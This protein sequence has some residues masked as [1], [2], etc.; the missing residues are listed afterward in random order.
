MP[1]IRR[2]ELDLNALAATVSNPNPLSLLPMPEARTPAQSIRTPNYYRQGYLDAFRHGACPLIVENERPVLLMPGEDAQRQVEVYRWQLAACLGGHRPAPGDGPLPG[3]DLPGFSVP[4]GF[5][6]WVVPWGVLPFP[7]PLGGILMAP[8]EQ[9][10]QFYR[11]LCAEREAATEFEAL[12]NLFVAARQAVDTLIQAIRDDGRHEPVEGPIWTKT[13]D[14]RW[15]H[16]ALW[17]ALRTTLIS[18]PGPLSNAYAA[19]FDAYRRALPV[20]Q[21]APSL[22]VFWRWLMEGCPTGQIWTGCNGMYDASDGPLA[23]GALPP[24]YV[25]VWSPD[26]CFMPGSL[27]AACSAAY[28]AQSSRLTLP[29]APDAVTLRSLEQQRRWL[30]DAEAAARAIA[31]DAQK[32]RP[33]SGKGGR[34]EDVHLNEL[35]RFAKRLGFTPAELASLIIERQPDFRD[36]EGFSKATIKERIRK[37]WTATGKNPPAKS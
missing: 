2:L 4:A 34:P 20:K 1:S 25:V 5:H 7:L 6:A 35:I 26:W 27:A 18:P 28:Q 12:P 13:T 3:L 21:P 9:M 11:V 37:R 15:K 10:V 32:L 33:T 22:D 14:A 19:Y 23:R 16:G 31:A 8:V 24:P 29:L 30:V 17:P 36:F